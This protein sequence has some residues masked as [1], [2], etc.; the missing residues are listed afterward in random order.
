MKRIL[1]LSIMCVCFVPAHAQLPPNDDCAGAVPLTVGNGFCT[2]PVIGTLTNATASVGVPAGCGGLSIDVWY[3]VVVISG[4]SVIVQTSAVGGAPYGNDMLLQAIQSSDNT[5]NGTLAQIGCDDD[6]NPD[7]PPSA[8]MSRL[9]ITNAG[10]S[11]NTY[12][13]RVTP[14]STFDIHPFAICAWTTTVPM[15]S[16]GSNCTNSIT[17]IDSAQKYMWVPLV[18][19]GGNIIAEIFP[20]GNKLGATSYSYYI[21]SGTIRSDVNSVKYLDRNITITPTL[22]PVSN[23]RVRLYYKSTELDALQLADPLVN[24]KNINATKTTNTCANSA[25]TITS[26]QFLNQT[27]NGLYNVT[28]SFINVNVP[29]FSTFFLHGGFSAL[30]PL[31]LLQFTVQKQNTITQ[32]SW[33]TIN[34]I[35]TSHFIV[36]RSNDGISF[37]DIG[38]VEAKNTIMNNT[39]AFTDSKPMNGTNFYRLQMTDRD[40]KI[41][42][43]NIAI[44]KI[45]SKEQQIVA[46]PN[47]VK[48]SESLQLSL[49]NITASKIE[50]INS[51]GQVVYSNSAKQTGSIGIPVSSVL[52]PGQYV[53]RIVSE[54]KV[55]TQKLLIKE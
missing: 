42:Y 34:E 35:N 49:Q 19:A 1:T 18:D 36:Q 4:Q 51:L 10:P 6:S 9:T 44:V 26:G 37:K 32:I 25:G 31:K 16:S 12:Y 47:P 41:T 5:C 33:L 8:V 38:R 11:A 17:N 46:Y 30:L 48:R 29:S 14:F 23:V 53:V 3:K 22:Q 50:I 28:D 20:N 54:D 39:Y 27:A 13:L 21:N 2:N 55:H 43:S 40:G 7:P 15:I 52:A 45:D 24:S